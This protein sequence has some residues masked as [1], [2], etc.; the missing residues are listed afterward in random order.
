MTT[1]R[2][3]ANG[4]ASSVETRAT[5][6]FARMNAIASAWWRTRKC[7][8]M[9]ML[10]FSFAPL[11]LF[12]FASRPPAYAV[13][14]LFRRF[15]AAF[16][17]C[18]A[19]GAAHLFG[20]VEKFIDFSDYHAGFVFHL[21]LV[22]W[23]VFCSVFVF[24]DL[25]DL[26]IVKRNSTRTVPLP[27]LRKRMVAPLSTRCSRCPVFHQHEHIESIGDGV[28]RSTVVGTDVV[29]VH[30]R[31]FIARRQL[32][33]G[34][35]AGNANAGAGMAPEVDPAAEGRA[36]A[37]CPPSSW[38]RTRWSWLFGAIIP[39]AVNGFQDCVAA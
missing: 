24:H 2:G 34:R 21:L 37:W 8:G 29:G 18:F 3:L 28:E 14:V 26:C 12:Y 22:N 39:V 35:D 32:H 4:F 15:A 17:L 5:N 38:R 9:Y 25:F 11:G 31:S 33:V 23:F 7:S 1:G 6:G 36:R 10:S 13:A 30:Q 20:A 16:N 19:A 27:G